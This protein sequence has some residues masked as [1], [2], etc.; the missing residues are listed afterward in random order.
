[1][2]KAGDISQQIMGWIQANYYLEMQGILLDEGFTCEPKEDAP[3]YVTNCPRS[4]AM[5]LHN[6]ALN[7]V[8]AKLDED[9][10]LGHFLKG[11]IKFN[12]KMKF[13]SDRDVDSQLQLEAQKA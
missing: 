8:L 13:F 11:A 6:E 4:K 1:M 3:W 5:Q 7:T 12:L 10:S 2:G 9:N